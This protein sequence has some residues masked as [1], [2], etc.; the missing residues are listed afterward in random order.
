[1]MALSLGVTVANGQNVKSLG[2]MVFNDEGILFVGDNISG[3]ILAF[4]FTSAEQKRNDFE[5]NL[6]NIDALIAAALGTAHGSVQV[7]DIAVHPKSGEVYLSV[8]RGHGLDALPALLKVNAENQLITIDITQ[9]PVTSQLLSKLPNIENKIGLRGTGRSAPTPK[10][11][12]KSERSLRTLAIVAMEY[13]NGE[14]FVAGISNEEFCSVLRRMSYPFNGTES[15][16]NIEMYHIVHDSY[17]T[18]APIRS[19]SVKTIDGKDH[20]VAAYTCSPLV[21]IPLEELQ[22]G[23]KV[24]AKTVGDMGNGQPIDMVPFKMKGEEMLFVTNNSRSPMVI[25]LKG[26]N[27]AKAVTQDDFERGPKLDVNPIM[28]YGPVGKPV[29]FSGAS[30]RIDLLND[31]KFISLNRDFETGNLD[32]ISL[33]TMVPFKLHNIVGEKDV[34]VQ[35]QK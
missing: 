18:R 35:K 28:P 1:M 22:N 30:L 14:L 15:I 31:S 33:N 9:V 26:L 24:K 8:T 19:M 27:G 23:Q 13:H 32:L 11:V 10:E 29:M 5:I 2:T 3:S 6:Y 20:L 16:S 17:E 7:N 12:A 25:P 21:L 4:D 34:P